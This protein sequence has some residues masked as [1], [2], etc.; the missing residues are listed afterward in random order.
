MCATHEGL[1]SSSLIFNISNSATL[2]IGRFRKFEDDVQRIFEIEQALFVSPKQKNGAT[3]EKRGAVS[4]S[5]FGVR[6]LNLE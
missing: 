4:Q 1:S 6:L 5:R 2:A 3:F